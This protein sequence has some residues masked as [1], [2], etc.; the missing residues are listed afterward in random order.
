[1]ADTSVELSRARAG[2]GNG[3]A[4]PA[5]ATVQGVVDAV[6][7]AGANTPRGVM[8]RI[9]AL[10][11][12]KEAGELEPILTTFKRVSNITKDVEAVT[13]DA[14]AL[15]DDAGKALYATF[16]AQLGHMERGDGTFAD[17]LTALRPVVDTFF[18]EVLVMAEEPELR[19]ARLGLLCTI[20][21]TFATFADFSRIQDRK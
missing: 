20:R 15:T 8:D 5:S 14:S 6:V 2:G 7:A 19:A 3:A 11:K 17:A 21:D 9:V 18:D 4:A 12:V 10:A 13:F 16:N 1:M